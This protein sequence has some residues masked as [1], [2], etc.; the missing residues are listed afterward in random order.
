MMAPPGVGGCTVA[1]RSYLADAR[2]AARSFVNHHP[3]SRFTILVV[4]GDRTPA[5]TWTHRDV[6]LVTPGE[7]GLREAELLAMAAIYSPFEIACALKPLVLRHV[8]AGADVA[9]YIDG[10]V[11]VL[12]PMP[13]LLAAAASHDV[14][15]VPHLVSPMPRDDR[16]PDEE[17]ILAAGTF[18]GGL[19]AVRRTSTDFL[20]WWEERLRRD[21]LA[22]PWAMMLADQRW[23]DLVPSLFDHHVLRDPTYDVAYWNLH[24]RPTSW[25]D[26]QL[27]VFDRPV[28]CFHYS[29]LSDERPWVLSTFAADRPRCSLTELPAVARLCRGWLARR[30]AVDANADRALGYHWAATADGTPLDRRSRMAFRDAL[31]EAE[32]DPTGRTPAPPSPFAEDGGATWRRWLTAPAPGGTVGRYLIHVWGEDPQRTGRFPPVHGSDRAA[33]LQWVASP[34]ADGAAIPDAFRPVPEEADVTPSEPARP[35]RRP[36]RPDAGAQQPV[37][38]IAT[39]RAALARPAEGPSGATGRVVDRVLAGR[40]RRADESAAALTAAVDELARRLADLSAR[41]DRTNDT[42]F[43]VEQ[44][45]DELADTSASTRSDAEEVGARLDR[46]AGDVAADLAAIRADLDGAHDQD[47]ITAGIVADAEAR[48]AEAL[49]DLRLRVAKLADEHPDNPDAAIP[50]AD[51]DPDP[52][53]DSTMTGS[54]PRTDA[55]DDLR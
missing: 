3:G 2:L 46:R 23:L 47:R 51:P 44:H 20:D 26:E 9:V 6:D 34:E 36:P 35:L 52:D 33:F 12:S 24:E 14:V 55:E 30:R 45:T 13:E 10:D 48:L 43:A 40:D 4:D 21:C 17:G 39:A 32:R 37:A 1:T 31:L 18:N 25:V 28:R 54:A 5:A 15:L 42:V 38:A 41:V 50:D 27:H 8:L 49:A 7:L 11:E 16:L 29:G 22:Q 19:L 53:E